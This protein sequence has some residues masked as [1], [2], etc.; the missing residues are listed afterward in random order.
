MR[1]R[2]RGQAAVELALA[3]L[4]FVTI[5][6]FGIHFSEIGF[7][8]LKVEEA[9]NAALWDVTAMKM[10]NIF[11]PE[12]T[13]YQSSV[14]TDA[15]TTTTRYQKYDGRASQAGGSGNVTQ[16]FT[17]GEPIKVTC[18]YNASLPNIT[19]PPPA[20]LVLP[21]ENA[22]IQCTA[23]AKL[24]GSNI[25]QDLLDS[26]GGWFHEVH[27]TKID[28]WACSQRRASGG[29]CQGNY[30]MLID[31]WGFAGEQEG[32]ECAVQD[33][34]SCKN[35]GYYGMVEKLFIG[36]LAAQGIDATK[37]AMDIVGMPPPYLPAEENSFS[38]SFRGSESGFTDTL[39]DSHGDSNWETTPYSNPSQY[40]NSYD[41]VRDSCFLGLSCN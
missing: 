5:L 11:T 7:L 18:D 25:P 30:P 29:N 21:S 1:V 41:N 2:Q 28:I 17:T 12:W 26:G 22:N 38:M 10:H 14:N 8:S 31:D 40:K 16:V 35:S 6:I 3:S 15:T 19:V 39:A 4:V 23:A 33:G 20:D 36:N 24:Y 27:W 32:Q 9:A 34:S 37:M 13:D